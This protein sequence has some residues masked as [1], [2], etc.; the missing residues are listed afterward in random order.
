MGENRC[1]ATQGVWQLPGDRIGFPGSRPHA[2][3]LHDRGH[4]LVV[5][6]VKG[7]GDGRLTK[8]A[9][10]DSCLLSPGTESRGIARG[11]VDPHRV[12][13]GLF[14]HGPPCLGK[15]GRKLQ[16]MQVD[17]LGDGP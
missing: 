14:R 2:E 11:H 6:L 17:A 8:K 12:E 9:K 13:E 1:R 7:H 10:V 4:R 15:S 16:G 5:G 3:K